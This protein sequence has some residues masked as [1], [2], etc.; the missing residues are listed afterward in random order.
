MKHGSIY[1]IPP[2]YATLVLAG[3]RP[4]ESSAHGM[5]W[6]VPGSKRAI[7]KSLEVLKMVMDERPDLRV[8]GSQQSSVYI[9]MKKYLSELAVA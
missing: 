9:A 7:D 4:E 5:I 3:I 6:Q 1:D 2:T 8:A